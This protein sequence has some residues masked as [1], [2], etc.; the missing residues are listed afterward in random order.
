MTK[1]RLIG[2]FEEYACGCVSDTEK[3]RKDLLGYC[4]I[5]GDDR[6]RVF[7][8]WARS[9]TDLIAKEDRDDER[10]RDGALNWVHATRDTPSLWFRLSSRS[11]KRGEPSENQNQH[12]NHHHRRNGSAAATRLPF[13]RTKMH[14]PTIRPRTIGGRFSSYPA[15]FSEA[16]IPAGSMIISARCN[17][18]CQ[19][20]EKRDELRQHDAT[21]SGEVYCGKN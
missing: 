19:W 14:S 1:P 9:N 15:W 10:A 12:R 20:R 3:R 16:T 11:G 21:G 17:A 6:R 4:A 8:H 7:K 18:R 13:S 2:Y 5:H